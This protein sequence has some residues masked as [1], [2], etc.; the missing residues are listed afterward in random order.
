MVQTLKLPP[1]AFDKQDRSPD[2]AF[3]V[4]P[5]FVTHIDDGA[6]AAVTTVY[7]EVLPAGGT[8]LDLMSSW[9]S[10]PCLT[11]PMPRWSATA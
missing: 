6:I 7:T 5:R 8:I 9:V 10:H 1:G 3:Y 4:Q 2:T 11:P